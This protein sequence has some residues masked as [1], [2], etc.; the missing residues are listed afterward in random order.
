MQPLWQQQ[1]ATP[2]H[3]IQFSTICLK[4]QRFSFTAL[5]RLLPRAELHAHIHG[6]NPPY[7]PHHSNTQSQTGCIRPSTF[8]DLRRTSAS[9][10]VVASSAVESW[11]Q[12][13][14]R[15]VGSC[16]SLDDCFKVFGAIHEVQAAT[17]AEN[18]CIPVSS[19][20]MPLCQVVSSCAAV[21]RVTSDALQ[22]ALH[23]NQISRQYVI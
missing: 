8:I 15:Q 19:L 20:T 13:E 5:I 11:A 1:A 10:R 9:A 2:S 22:V 23:P 18:F 16:L 6:M 21:A 14:T 4:A 3:A 17:A 7:H 12:H